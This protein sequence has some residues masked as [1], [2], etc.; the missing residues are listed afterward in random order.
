[1]V[2]ALIIG[3]VAVRLFAHEQD[4]EKIHKRQII[5]ITLPSGSCDARVVRTNSNKLIVKL[6]STTACGSEG[7]IL[8]L[9]RSEVRDVVRTSEGHR[10]ARVA[11]AA[12]SSV[13][14]VIAGT[15]IAF[16]T[17]SGAAGG[18]VIAGG[19]IAPWLLMSKS[20][21]YEV[22]VNAIGP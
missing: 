9:A 15:A 8:T 16:K 1:M 19:L 18:A 7:R 6:R 12:F 20:I 11:V 4:F 2:K 21:Q 13:G 3:L 17:N 5:R 14:L 22:F 10:V